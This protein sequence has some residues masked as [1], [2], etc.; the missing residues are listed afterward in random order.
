MKAEN[1]L[2]FFEINSVKVKI[3]TDYKHYYDYLKAYFNRVVSEEIAHGNFDIYIN[4][5]WREELDNYFNHVKKESTLSGLAANTLVSDSRIVTFRKMGKKKKIIFDIRVGDNKI[6][7]KVIV[8]RKAVE[9]IWRYNFLRKNKNELFYEITYPIV[10]Y[11]LLWYL[12]YFRRIHCLHA[13]AI[14]VKEKG[15]VLCGLEG[16]GKTSLA[17]SL[18][19][20]NDTRFVSDNLVLYDDEKVYPCYELVR[21]HKEDEAYLWE[22]KFTKVIEASKY[23]DFYAPLVEISRKGVKPDILVFPQ[24]SPC[25]FVQEIPKRDAIVRA[26]LLSYLPSELNNYSEYRR[27]YNLLDLQF[28]PWESQCRGLDKLLQNVK[29]YVMGMS[30]GDGLKKNYQ[31]F[32]ESIVYAG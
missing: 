29:C 28:N 15:V 20:E 21:V 2:V 5:S 24:F 1:K 25:F 6:L 13:S 19:G 14:G 32:K 11:L 9:D 4:V 8:K 7:A 16:V 31:R 17:L 30:K 3:E 27:L 18:L 26:L 12:E 10:Y 22:G 23:K